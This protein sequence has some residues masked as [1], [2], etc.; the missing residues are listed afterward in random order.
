[1]G[2]RTLYLVR[3]GQYRLHQRDAGSLTQKGEAQAALT[4]AALKDIPFSVIYYSPVLRAVQTADIIGAEL[5]NTDRV[6]HE[7]LRECIPSIPNRYAAYFAG[8]HPDL[9]LEHVNDCAEK[10]EGAFNYY[11][12]A[13]E[14]DDDLY[15]MLVCHGNVIRYL[16]SRVLDLNSD[17][18]SKMLI[19]NCG[20]SR[21]L[22]DHDGQMYLISHN[23]IGHL[24]E[25]LRTDN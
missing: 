8:A 22:V 4:A 15:E 14:S 6:E 12:R 20:V 7:A 5:P 25:E 10:L 11:F 16:V 24:P 18:W 2:K 17:G 23:D 19:N 13:N 3:H 21:I 1:M 9:T